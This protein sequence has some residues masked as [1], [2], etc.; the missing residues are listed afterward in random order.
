LSPLT[1]AAVVLVVLVVLTGPLAYLPVSALAAVVFLIAVELIDLAGMRRILAVRKHEFVVALLTAAAVVGLGVEYGIV[2]AVI[3]SMVDHLRHSYSPLN[4]VLVKSPEGHWR[5]VPVGPGART[6]EGLVVYRFGTSLYYA[7]A[8]R[9]AQDIATLA[10][11][12][13]P[14]RW[15]VLDWAA[16]GDVDYTAST[17]LV[18]AVEHLHQRHI[19]LVFSSVLGPVRGQL[20][21]Y[22][23]SADGYYD[24]PGEALEAFEG[25]KPLPA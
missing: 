24:T 4:S 18:K 11:H 2:L 15:L 25:S 17:V 23:I 8:A 9:L 7:N 3:A 5:A 10:G 13:T 16:I 21:R 20:G 14:L 22:G 1:A 19:R 12:G 6:D